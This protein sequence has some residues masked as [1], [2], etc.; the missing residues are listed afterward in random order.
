VDNLERILLAVD[1]L[2][3]AICSLNEGCIKLPGRR[4]RPLGFFFLWPAESADELQE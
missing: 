3:C 2:G 1:D 4:K